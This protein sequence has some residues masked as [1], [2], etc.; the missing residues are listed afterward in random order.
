ML[1]KLPKANFAGS[2]LGRVTRYTSGMPST[3]LL[4][5]YLMNDGVEGEDVT[6]L[7]DFS[8]RGNH[9]TLL[10]GWTPAVQRSYGIEITNV[11]GCAYEIPQPV[12]LP[13]R[14]MTMLIA[15]KTTIPEDESA[16]FNTFYGST[17]NEN[18]LLPNIA[19]ANQPALVL[20]Y[21]CQTSGHFQI[22]DAGSDLVLAST[23]GDNT[24]GPRL[25]EPGIV[26]MELDISNDHIALHYPGET[27]ASR[28]GKETA[29]T[30]FYD[31]V[32][33]RGNMLIGS[34]RRTWLAAGK[35]ARIASRDDETRPV[36]IFQDQPGDH[37]AGGY[38]VRLLPVVTPECRRS[39]S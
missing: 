25:T 17:A 23:T 34:V 15:A 28:D 7:T 14:D 37:P 12:N 21:S 19:H 20:N 10:D 9:A 8:G 35:G 22:L 31:G 3:D 30:D 5:L 13:G 1:I 4:G 24:R 18:Q 39:A 26:A 32:T 16:V 11:D 29:L 36:Q 6:R 2:N 38:D 27:T 33:D